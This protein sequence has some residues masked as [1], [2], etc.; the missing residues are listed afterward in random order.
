MKWF[1][2]SLCTVSVIV[3]SSCNETISP[4]KETVSVEST[5]DSIRTPSLVKNSTPSVSNDELIAE[6]TE[7]KIYLSQID[8]ILQ[9]RI[10]HYRDV[11]KDE[12][13][14]WKMIL[15]ERRRVL[16]T[17]VDNY[18][19]LLE[20]YNRNLEVTPA[21]REKILREFRGKFETEEEYQKHLH[22]AGKSE[23]ELSYALAN[24][25]LGPKC[26][27]DQ[28]KKIKESIN[29]ETMKAF[30][31]EK[32]DYFSPPGRTDLNRVLIQS[33]ED[34]T[35]EEAKALAEKLY[36]EVKE[37]I[38]SL[39]TFQE[40]RKVIQDYAVNYSDAPEADYNYGF[41]N[42]Y[43]HEISKEKYSKD[44]LEEVERVQ[45]GKLSELVRL[46]DGYVFFLVKNKVE[47]YVHPY[48]SDTV[49]NMLPKM[50]MKEKK[51]E[52]RTELRKKFELEIYEEKLDEKKSSVFK[53]LED[54]STT[55]EAP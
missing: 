15:K 4:E 37:K 13:L 27:E 1:Q 42:V 8:N 40:K 39:D 11:T 9:P 7:G 41:L 55:A 45:E 21:E 23:E 44:F 33:N 10:K 36:A 50:Y 12:S 14:I 16:E 47:P 53:S 38:A 19:L 34:R 5:S 29:S 20:A 52:W 3:F 18:L 25:Q 35:L 6:W 43:H 46:N 22:Q 51:E 49:Q 28:E 17:L 54:T 30:Y 48:E 26:I 2:L 32:I 31:E 24:V